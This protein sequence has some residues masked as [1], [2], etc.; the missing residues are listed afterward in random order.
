M[1]NQLEPCAKCGGAGEVVYRM[2]AY[3]GRCSRCLSPTRAFGTVTRTHEEAHRL[4]GDEWDRNQRM[5]RGEGDA[6]E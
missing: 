6:D 2:S 3:E 1:N 4:A 5:M